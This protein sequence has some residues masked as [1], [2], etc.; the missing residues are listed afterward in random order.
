M[1]RTKRAIWALIIAWGALSLFS[2]SS[3]SRNLSPGAGSSGAASSPAPAGFYTPP[4]AVLDVKYTSN[5]VRID[6]PTAQKALR[7][8]SDD[9][10]LFL[11]DASDPRISELKE[12][13]V[14]F[15]E[16]L[17][18]RKVI[19]VQS[20]GSQL[21]VLTDEAALTDFIQDGRIEFSMPVTFQRSQ[22]Q[23]LP[24]FLTPDPVG[25]FRGWFSS[26]SLVYAGGEEK[27]SAFSAH[28]KGEANGWEF[29]LEGEPEGE[30]FSMGLD[31]AKK[32][33]GL[34]ASIKAKGD[35]S[36]ISTGFK[37]V[38]QSAK[39]QDFE[40]STPLSGKIH[41][42]W[43]ALSSEGD[44]NIGE[45]RLKLPPFAKQVI[46]I[47]GI[48]FMFR[49]DE[50]LIF[51]PGFGTSHDAAQGGFTMNYD[52]TGGV[53]IHG[54][55][56]QPQGKMDGDMS[57][58]KTTSESMAAHG[59]VL[60]VNAPKISLSL[61]TESIKEAIQ[62]SIPG[63]ILDKAAEALKKSPFFSTLLKKAKEDFF[64]IEGGAYV[65][66]VTEFDY[67]GSG[68]LSMVPCQ[69]THMN[70]LGQAGA[71]AQFL[72]VK[73]EASHNLFTKKK[74]LREPDAPICGEK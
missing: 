56:S 53:S 55:Q 59:I 62:E 71:D 41:V 64:K 4:N 27:K 15:L 61:G 50:N 70:L 24:P 51:K 69:L 7:S 23:A 63:A 22:A 13:K 60:A 47:Y 3:C 74:A 43:A 8:V 46:D 67:T 19:G 36:H 16:H 21:A 66:L 38:V 29:E 32:L 49:I 12:G 31:V 10:S 39:I 11:F 73:G 17:G 72:A 14:M 58:E 28:L 9:G 48:P 18:V 20:Q 2:C 45:S 37:A 25:A 52:G 57:L 35:V 54:D 68:P 1:N 44:H 6:F 5:T 42:T 34:T 40:Y 30:G 33:A 65:Q 26:P